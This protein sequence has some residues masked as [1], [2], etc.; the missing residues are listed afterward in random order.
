[1]GSEFREL[2]EIKSEVPQGSVLEPLL[3][4]IFINNLIFEV[5]ESEIC[6]FAND[7]R[8][9]NNIESVIL[10]L[11]KDL[12]NT[13]NWFRVNPMAPNPG[14]FQVMFLGMR[15]SNL[16]LLSGLII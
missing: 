7:I 3:F 1:M 5:A 11:E 8:S 14:K 9:S 10:S 15:K 4:N 12:S 13:L 16:N 6:N 2:L